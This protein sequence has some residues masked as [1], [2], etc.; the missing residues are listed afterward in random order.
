MINS[1]YYNRFDKAI[2]ISKITGEDMLTVFFRLMNR[3]QFKRITM[4]ELETK[5]KIDIKYKQGIYK[6]TDADN[7]IWLQDC[8]GYGQ[9]PEN[10]DGELVLWSKGSILIKEDGATD[11]TKGWVDFNEGYIPEVKH[12]E[13]ANGWEETYYN[14]CKKENK[15][16]PYENRLPVYLK[17]YPGDT[18]KSLE[19]KLT[20]IKYIIN[21]PVWDKKYKCFWIKETQTIEDT[22]NI[23]R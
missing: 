22:Q 20:D 10:P 9:N 5:E 7:Y 2:E 13:P 16:I 14:R 15:L 8:E 18:K 11:E 23:E 19:K 17:N 21:D 1:K 12:I 3:E 4:E 6:V